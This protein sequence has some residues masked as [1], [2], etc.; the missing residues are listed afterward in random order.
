M[1][2]DD[3]ITLCLSTQVGCALDCK[4][5]ATSQLDIKVYDQRKKIVDQYLSELGARYAYN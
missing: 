1:N 4:F 3:R 2:D 5:C